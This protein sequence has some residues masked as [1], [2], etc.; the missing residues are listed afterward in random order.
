MVSSDKLGKHDPVYFS[1]FHGQL[2]RECIFALM[3]YEDMNS[4]LKELFTPPVDFTA[5]KHLV[6]KFW[7]SVEALLMATGNISKIFWPSVGKRDPRRSRIEKRCAVLR[8]MWGIEHG[9]PFSF[10]TLRNHFEHFDERVDRWYL[11][12]R[13]LHLMDSNFFQLKDLDG[14]DPE[15]ILRNFDPVSW[16][17]Y[18]MGDIL[19]VKPLVQ[20]VLD[21]RGNLQVGPS[22]LGSS[23]PTQMISVKM[24]PK[25]DE[26]N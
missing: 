6:D 17:L 18:F 21:L 8:K 12:D 15:D 16:T 24:A 25:E 5:K 23:A 3:A 9:S 14:Y 2:G 1:V 26:K 11:N 10:R 4:S 19:E 22:S 7:Y 20:A 13:P